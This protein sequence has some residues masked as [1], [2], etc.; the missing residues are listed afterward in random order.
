MKLATLILTLIFS[1][2]VFSETIDLGTKE[3][4]I[5]PNQAKLFLHKEPFDFHTANEF[6]VTEPYQTFMGNMTKVYLTSTD[7]RNAGTHIQIFNRR[8]WSHDPNFFETWTFIFSRPATEETFKY[9]IKVDLAACQLKDMA[10][11]VNE[12]INTASYLLRQIIANPLPND[13]RYHQVANII[14]EVE[15]MLRDMVTMEQERELYWEILDYLENSEDF[16]R[17][18]N[19]NVYARRAE[20]ALTDLRWVYVNFQAYLNFV[21]REYDDGF[22]MNRIPVPENE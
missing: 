12:L 21:Q 6:E 13:M 20:A 17:W 3:V 11:R 14:N 18:V 1:F 7:I 15:M 22:E 10:E 9:S 8:I 19:G 4:V 16:L 5:C 2:S